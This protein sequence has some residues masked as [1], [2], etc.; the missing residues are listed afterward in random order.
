MKRKEYRKKY[1]FIV[2]IVL[3]LMI[4]PRFIY[5]VEDKKFTREIKEKNQFL[6][7]LSSE[8]KSEKE[9]QVLAY[10]NGLISK[11]KNL[12]KDYEDL[13]KD[14][15]YPAYLIVPS[16]DWQLP[17]KL[18]QGYG[19]VHEQGSSLPMEGL[20]RSKLRYDSI[21]YKLL[22]V[23]RLDSLAINDRIYIEVFGQTLAYQVVEGPWDENA[24]KK[25]NEL[26]LVNGR[27]T[28]YLKKTSYNSKVMEYDLEL[29]N[30]YR[31]RRLKDYGLV[32]VLLYSIP[33]IFRR[34]EYL[35]VKEAYN[36]KLQDQESR[37]N[38]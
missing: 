26:I 37:K 25:S 7:G 5:L 27:K 30:I 14:Q 9:G 29:G 17:I 33:F 10:N 12:D 2:T 4:L 3:A 6:A 32:I 22:P 21:F 8:G 15:A 16:L 23:N 36:K 20:V 35:E 1:Y 31:K 18:G 19:L 13:V 38:T 28:I 24:P 34:E 11:K